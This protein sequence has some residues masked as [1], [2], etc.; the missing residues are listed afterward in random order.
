MTPRMVGL[1]AVVVRLLWA[2]A[3]AGADRLVAGNGR[4]DEAGPVVDAAGEGLGVVEALRAEPH[5]DG[6]RTL[7]VVAEDDD[8]VVG[9]EFGEGARGDLA[10]GHEDGARE[11]GF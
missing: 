3:G 11:A 7:A 9:I 2:G 4:V 1:T 5:G 10:H 8:V 6:E